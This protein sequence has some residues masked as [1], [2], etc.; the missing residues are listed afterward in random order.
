MSFPTHKLKAK[1][2]ETSS[3]E[4]DS[5][6]MTIFLYENNKY[7]SSVQYEF[8]SEMK[9][10][11]YVTQEY[12]LD[13]AWMRSLGKNEFWRKEKDR[14]VVHTHEIVLQKIVKKEKITKVIEEDNLMF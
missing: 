7:K 13:R 10:R 5:W 14:K 4:Y 9:M 11:D 2:T 3:R 8:D 6:L 12:E 1:P